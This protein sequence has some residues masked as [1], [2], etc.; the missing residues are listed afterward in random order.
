MDLKKQNIEMIR[1]Y[2]ER[3]ADK[4]QEIKRLQYDLA[5]EKMKVADKSDET[6]L[7]QKL[8]HLTT[9]HEATLHHNSMLE[10]QVK[11]L[12]ARQ[13]A[14]ASDKDAAL[15]LAHQDYR[16]KLKSVSMDLVI[17]RSQNKS[18]EEKILRLEK[19]IKDFENPVENQTYQHLYRNERIQN[20]KLEEMIKQQQEQ[21]AVLVKNSSSFQTVASKSATIL[22][23]ESILADNHQGTLIR[24]FLLA[25]ELHRKSIAG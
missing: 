25:L 18:Y 10:D 24:N 19:I 5:A 21:I 16:E 4:F 3:L 22:Q 15:A 23:K 14:I 2:E 6:L 11:G 8:S 9:I 20:Q 12:L 7:R 17:L 1:E 13:D